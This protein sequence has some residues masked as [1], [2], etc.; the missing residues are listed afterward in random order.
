QTYSFILPASVAGKQVWIR[1]LDMDHTVGNTNLDT[2]FVDQMYIR[3]ATPSGT[4]GVSLAGPTTAVNAIDADDQDGEHYAALVVGASG[5]V[6]ISALP[7]HS[8]ANAITALGV[9]DVNG[10]GPDDVVVGTSSD[11]WYWSNQNNGVS[12]TSAINVDSVGA[13]VYSI[14]LGDASK[15]QYV[16]R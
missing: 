16:G 15:A 11:I 4:T 3:A 10:D 1:T 12:W 13:N 7:V 5:T 9:G 8:A 14:D 6:I 2:L